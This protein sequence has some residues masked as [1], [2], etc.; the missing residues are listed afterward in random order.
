MVS[1]ETEKNEAASELA[2][3]AEKA[4]YII[5]KAREF[6]EEVAPTGPDARLEPDG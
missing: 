3:S 6:D 4:F 1:A 5:V 2:I